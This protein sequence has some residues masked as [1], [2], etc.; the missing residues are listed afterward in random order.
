MTHEKN[1]KT[2]DWCISQLAKMNVD[3]KFVELTADVV[4][5]FYNVNWTHRQPYRNSSAGIFDLFIYIY[6][7]HRLAIHNGLRV[8]RYS[9]NVF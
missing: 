7:Q 5:I 8:V 1:L 2:G 4:R 9:I 6:V 3:P